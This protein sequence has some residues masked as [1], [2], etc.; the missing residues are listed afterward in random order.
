M[1]EKKNKSIY[2]IVICILTC[3]IGFMIGKISS[4]NTPINEMEP[5]DNNVTEKP[6]EKTATCNNDC[7]TT[8]EKTEEINSLHVFIPGEEY[9]VYSYL[10]TPGWTE[11]IVDYEGELYYT[12]ENRQN[13]CYEKLKKGI[14]FDN[15][16]ARCD[17]DEDSEGTIRRFNVKTSDVKNAYLMESYDATDGRAMAMIVFKDGTVNRYGLA[18][19]G[20][21]VKDFFKNYKVK[22]IKS[23]KCSGG[24]TVCSKEKFTL[25]LQD[26]TTIDLEMELEDYY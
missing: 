7:N 25:V 2:I 4:N 23:Y 15:N 3:L 5:K 19:S 8:C 26:D 16:R 14:K 10:K 24:D 9:N 17:E 13:S 20:Y 11:L 12:N 22:A 1:E 18:E 21:V 6:E